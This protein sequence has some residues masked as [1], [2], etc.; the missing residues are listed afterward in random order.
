MQQAGGGGGSEPAGSEVASAKAL[1]AT[2]SAYEVASCD[3]W[4]CERTC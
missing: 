3:L 2:T 4:W 1:V